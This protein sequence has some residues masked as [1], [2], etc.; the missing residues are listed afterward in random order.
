MTKVG[1]LIF[2]DGVEQGLERGME[3]G[4]EML[5]RTCKDF[6]MSRKAV[7]AKIKEESSLSEE[8]I[9]EYLDKYW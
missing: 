5:I 7:L 2:D 3:Q 6:H 8:K 1:Q 9:T 4:I